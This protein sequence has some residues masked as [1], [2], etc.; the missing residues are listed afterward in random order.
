MPLD[1]SFRCICIAHIQDYPWDH[2]SCHG[3]VPQE[4][5]QANQKS[6]TLIGYPDGPIGWGNRLQQPLG[7]DSMTHNNVNVGSIMP[8]PIILSCDNCLSLCPSLRSLNPLSL[9]MAFHYE[10][11]IFLCQASPKELKKKVCMI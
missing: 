1:R 8:S 6:S 11:S 9:L 5:G 10:F 4:I 3:D 7:P 2:T